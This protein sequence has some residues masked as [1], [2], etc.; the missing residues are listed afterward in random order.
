[1]GAASLVMGEAVQ[2]LPEDLCGRYPEIP[3]RRIA[4]TRDRLAHGYNEVE[5]LY[6]ISA[7]GITQSLGS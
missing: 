6:G 5:G 3:L 7:F 1:M 2:R 4:S